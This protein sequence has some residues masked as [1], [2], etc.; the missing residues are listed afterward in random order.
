[1]TCLAVT[2]AC[3]IRAWR[4][5][6]Q[7]GLHLQGYV[8]ALLDD[9]PNHKHAMRQPSFIEVVQHL[10]LRAKHGMGPRILREFSTVS[11]PISYTNEAG[12]FVGILPT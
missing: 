9:G 2:A 7:M 12:T 10:L 6:L 8:L 11:N 1:M 5:G 3:P 4:N